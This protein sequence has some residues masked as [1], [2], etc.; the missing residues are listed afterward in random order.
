MKQL[1][2]LVTRWKKE[3]DAYNAQ[4]EEARSKGLGC[5]TTVGIRTSLRQCA[6]EL[7][8]ALKELN[9]DT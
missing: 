3:S 8:D 7:E 1:N 6:K 9:H 5:E 2:D 4:I